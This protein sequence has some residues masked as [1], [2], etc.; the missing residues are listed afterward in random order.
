MISLGTIV[1]CTPYTLPTSKFF[2]EVARFSCLG[3]VGGIS[4]GVGRRSVGGTFWNK[5]STI[6]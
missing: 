3:W 2:L 6:P 4:Y 1:F 5:G